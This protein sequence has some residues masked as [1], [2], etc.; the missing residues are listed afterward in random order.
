MRH[1]LLTRIVQFTEQKKSLNRQIH[2]FIWLLN[3][4]PIN[5]TENMPLKVKG[6]FDTKFKKILDRIF[7]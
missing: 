3:Y 5:F 6:S 1:H 7:F 2:N 4:I